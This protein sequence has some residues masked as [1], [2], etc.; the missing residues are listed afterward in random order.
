MTVN[1]IASLSTVMATAQ[2]DQDIG[3]AVLKKSIDIAANSVV[4]LLAAIPG[5][6][7]PVNL[8]ANL[9]QN[10]NTTAWIRCTGCGSLFDQVY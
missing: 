9:G 8:P 3:M 1:G 4:E 10:I 5:S 2:T 7:P 6:P